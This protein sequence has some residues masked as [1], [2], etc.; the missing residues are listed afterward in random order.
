[1][2]IAIFHLGFFYSGGGEKLV[3]EEM[4][5][6]R[7]LGHDVDCYAPFVDRSHC[8]PDVPEM[9]EIR[10]IIPAPP[11][12]LPMKDP[13]SVLLSCILIP[14]LAWRFRYY[15]IFVGAN[16][17]GAWFA[18]IVGKV[19]RKPYVVYLAQALRLLHPRQVD[20]ENGIRIREGDALFIQVL[21][22]T[23]GWL[24]D[25]ADRF[26]IEYAAAVLTNGEHVS[27]WIRKVYGIRTTVCA[28]GCHPVPEHQLRYD[29]RW[30]SSIELSGITIS[31]P[32]ILLTN[33]HS[34]MKRFEYALWALKAI[35]RDVPNVSLI[36]T[37]QETEYTAQLRYLANGLGI[38]NSVGFIGLVPD[39]EL[40]T[41]YSDAA[42]YVYP[43]PEEDFGM[44]VVEAMSAGTPVVAW[45]NGGPTVTVKHNET[46]YL[47]EP[48]DTEDFATKLQFLISNPKIA[49]Q[50][51][52]AGHLR[53]K[54]EF[55]YKHHNKIMDETLNKAMRLY[56]PQITGNEVAVLDTLWAERKRSENS[57]RTRRDR[58]SIHRPNYATPWISEERSEAVYIDHIR[59]RKLFSSAVEEHSSSERETIDAFKSGLKTGD[60]NRGKW[61]KRILSQ[62]PRHEEQ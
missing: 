50:L 58:V 57:L 33:R 32:Y 13:I 46:G 7:K 3:L 53:A 8:F 20:L 41:L 16:Q 29:Q 25:R 18:F 2:R 55:S 19:L 51:G 15:D 17:P 35:L 62:K 39:A 9:A 42:A 4:R 44:G 28:A 60:E 26:S 38:A 6:L 48:Y 43:S 27:R 11:S 24:I 10:S 12:W 1:M 54:N 61:A 49:E 23:A 14:F 59:D 47:I 30:S 40:N 56:Y 52:R 22:K 31:K 5:G 34:P 37:G 21:T 45:N 36:I